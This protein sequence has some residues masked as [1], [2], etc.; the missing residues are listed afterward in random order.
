MAK[1]KGRQPRGNGH[2]NGGAGG[3]PYGP[4]DPSRNVLDLVDAVIVRLRT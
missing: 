2:G 4:Y 1:K 3:T